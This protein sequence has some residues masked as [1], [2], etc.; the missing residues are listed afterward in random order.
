MGAASTRHSLHPLHFEEGDD[1]QNSGE[2][3]RENADSH[4]LQFES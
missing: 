3:R 1:E 4:P 2:M